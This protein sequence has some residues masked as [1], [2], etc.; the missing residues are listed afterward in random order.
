MME[1]VTNINFFNK[2]FFCKDIKLGQEKMCLKCKE[3]ANRKD[4]TNT[5]T[6]ICLLRLCG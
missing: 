1:M 3:K 4:I 6:L 5:M 2:A